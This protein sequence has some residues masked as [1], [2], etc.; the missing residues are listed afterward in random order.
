MLF[1]LNEF[2][3]AELA[4]NTPRDY[5][6][7]GLIVLASILI[8]WL[9]KYVLIK[10]AK[11]VAEHT[12]SKLDDAVVATLN[13]FNWPFY[14]VMALY[15]A[16]YFLQ[17][18]EYVHR[19]GVYVI[20]V[21][22]VYYIAKAVQYLISYGFKHSIDKHQE[23]D[24]DFNPASL[25]FAGRLAKGA[26]WI[27]AVILVMQ[28][29]GYEITT[30]VAGLGIGG[31]A[32]AFALQSVLTDIFASFSIYFD[33]PFQIGDYIEIGKDKGHV[34]KIGI[35]STRLE[36]LQGEELIISN[37]ELT[38]SRVSNFKKMD[39]RR[40]IFRIYLEYGTPQEKLELI[41]DLMKKIINGVDQASYHKTYFKQFSSSGLEYETLYYIATRKYDVWRD[42]QHQIN[43]AV[44]EEFEKAGIA[45]ADPTDFATFKDSISK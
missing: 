19:V 34:K 44:K 25:D 2:I 16:S 32:V 13:A 22:V 23:A 41:P 43:M 21:V 45:I 18:P 42:T 27:V 9:F 17:L 14:I 15:V 4:A 20:L 26:I 36:T 7:A 38:E 29:L 24:P 28:N 37:Q 12:K 3:P 10:R 35:K 11:R 31:V 5:M 1:N 6:I 40:V 30:L 8:L 39:K 33:K